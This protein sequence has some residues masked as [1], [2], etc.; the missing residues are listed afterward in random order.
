[1]AMGV[2]HRPGLKLDIVLLCSKAMNILF[3]IRVDS[4]LEFFISAL[5]D[6]IQVVETTELSL[7]TC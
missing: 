1:M 3:S 4:F 6:M 7:R 5:D 2:A